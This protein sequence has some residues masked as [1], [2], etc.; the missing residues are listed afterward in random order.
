MRHVNPHHPEVSPDV[1]PG[2]SEHEFRSALHIQKEKR[3][4]RKSRNK[5]ASEHELIP[6]MTSQLV[7]SHKQRQ[8]RLG[9]AAD[10]SGQ[11]VFL[12]VWQVSPRYWF[13][14]K[15]GYIKP[16]KKTKLL[17]QACWVCK[18]RLRAFFF[19]LPTSR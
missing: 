3:Q 7:T 16:I 13:P 8:A 12:G 11:S 18:N 4:R 10:S 15:T 14:D 17:L 2:D 9:G 19:M 5:F 1:R 6:R